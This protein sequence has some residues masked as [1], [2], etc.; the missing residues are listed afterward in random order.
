MQPDYDRIDTTPGCGDV[1][2]PPQH[3]GDASGYVAWA[4]MQLQSNPWFRQRIAM[5]AYG[6]YGKSQYFAK[7][8][9]VGEFAETLLRLVQRVDKRCR[10]LQSSEA[11]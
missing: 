10:D 7:P 6:L 1:F 5:L 2:A 4:K 11:A 8:Q 3:P 9:V